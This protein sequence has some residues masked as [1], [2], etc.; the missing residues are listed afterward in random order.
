MNALTKKI[1]KTF[2]LLLFIISLLVPAALAQE[3][4]QLSLRPLSDDGQ[5]V[6]LELVAENVT[7]MYGAE[8]RVS[9]DPTLVAV[10]DAQPDKEGVQIE[11]GTL[12]PANQ[13]FVV[14]NAVD[15]AAGTITFAMTLLNPAPA[16]TGSGPLAPGSGSRWSTSFSHVAHRENSAK[17]N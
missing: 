17:G 13:G 7:D 11:V 16:A 5:V 6:V 2:T 8:F 9:Y 14:A 15:E 12:L 10:Q 1:L 3:V 4:A